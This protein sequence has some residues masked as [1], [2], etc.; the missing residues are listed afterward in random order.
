MPSIG[1]TAGPRR[2]WISV[3]SNLD[4]ERSIRG[5]IED[6]RAA[7][8][9]LIVSP[10]YETEAVGFEGDPF[11][12]LVVGVRTNRPVGDIRR[13]LRSIEDSHGRVR[14]PDKFASRILDLDLLTWGSTVGV[15]DGY[16]LPRDEILKYP[17]VL[18]PL[19]DVAPEE[20]HPVDGRSYRQL[21]STMAVTSA[22]LHPVAL[23]L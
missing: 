21:W 14:G 20:R 17:F 11:Y 12:N 6:L 19:A 7:F 9:T 22:P 4:R 8:V 23:A 3:G 5:A 15:V 13:R 2:C 1:E 18:A 10:I 16:K